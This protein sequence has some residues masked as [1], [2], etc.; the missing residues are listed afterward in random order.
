M[1]D[2]VKRKLD[3]PTLPGS[4]FASKH[5]RKMSELKLSDDAPVPLSGLSSFFNAPTDQATGFAF[6]VSALN[7]F[8]LSA[9][10]IGKF[11]S[12]NPV[13]KPDAPPNVEEY[14]EKTEEILKY[15]EPV[16]NGPTMSMAME[17]NVFETVELSK[18]LD[19]MLRVTE[20]S[21]Q[22]REKTPLS[23]IQNKRR[24]HRA[25]VQRMT[26][27]LN[28]ATK[29]LETLYEDCDGEALEEM[30]I[31][32]EKCNQALGNLTIKAGELECAVQSTLSDFKMVVSKFNAEQAEVDALDTSEL[33]RNAEECTEPMDQDTHL[34]MRN[35]RLQYTR[36]AKD[37][38]KKADELTKAAKEI[39][40]QRLHELEQE[41]AEQI[42]LDDSFAYHHDT[43]IFSY[44]RSLHLNAVFSIYN[45]KLKI[46]RKIDVDMAAAEAAAEAAEE[47]EAEGAEEAAAEDAEEV[48]KVE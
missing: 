48:A 34:A 42:D 7:S 23:F 13:P 39:K 8:N 36:E 41:V 26:Q 31:A 19:Q 14:H 5:V 47:A 2:R 4:S 22:I 9:A 46:A 37:N 17:Q 24:E 15:F 28:K 44:Q 30:A 25:A 3:D 27:N 16:M 43:N 45:K 40:I 10:S 18:Q 33:E 35:E 1:P 21:D 20:S 6:D 12:F 29:S 11:S 32:N 38:E